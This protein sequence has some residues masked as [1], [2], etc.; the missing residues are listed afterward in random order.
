[1]TW[2]AVNDYG[3]QIDYRTYDCAGL[4]PLPAQGLGGRRQERPLGGAL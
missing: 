1:M 3:I 4:G 2:R